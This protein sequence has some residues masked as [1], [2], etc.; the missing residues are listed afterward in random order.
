MGI[1][2]LLWSSF[3][4][5]SLPIGTSLI[6]HLMISV[7]LGSV[8][9]MKYV[10]PNLPCIPSCLTISWKNRRS[11]HDEINSYRS[12]LEVVHVWNIWAHLPVSY[13]TSQRLERP[14]TMGLET[15]SPGPNK[16]LCSFE[17]LIFKVLI[18]VWV[19][20]SPKY[21]LKA[22]IHSLKFTLEMRPGAFP[23]GDTIQDQAG[24]TWADCSS[25]LVMG[26]D[27]RTIVF[28]N[29]ISTGC[30]HWLCPFAVNILKPN[31]ANPWSK[32]NSS[33]S[34]NGSSTPQL[35]AHHSCFLQAPI[36]VIHCAP[37]SLVFH[38]HSSLTA[39]GSIL[40]PQL[41]SCKKDRT[42]QRF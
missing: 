14:V 16:S 42:E 38:F 6:T 21:V 29:R 36:L 19:E 22:V 33:R 2:S 4:D 7:S 26:K 8:S 3:L 1:H 9:I 32:M 5:W 31:G 13:D 20:F 41:Q 39:M 10:C 34:I 11:Y 18:T 35:S 30:E 40:Q 15:F 24:L 25:I 23:T 37:F 27:L 28:K 17:H 12:N